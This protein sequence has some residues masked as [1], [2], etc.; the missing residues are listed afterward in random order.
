M[1]INKIK[2]MG[3]YRQQTEGTPY[4]IYQACLGCVANFKNTDS[5][6]WMSLPDEARAYLDKELLRRLAEEYLEKERAMP[7]NGQKLFAH[8]IA[9]IREVDEKIFQTI[10]KQGVHTMSDRELLEINQKLGSQTYKMWLEFFM[11]IFDVDAEG[12]IEHELVNEKI[13]LLPEEKNIMMLQNELLV[14]QREEKNL[15]QIAVQIKNNPGALNTFLYLSAPGNLHRLKL[16]PEIEKALEQHQKNFFWTKNSWAHTGTVPIFDYVEI[17]KQMLFSS[18]DT[19]EE[20]KRLESFEKD[21]L[22]KK[23]M[24]IKKYNL[25]PWL[26]KMFEFF[27]L[28]SYWRDE[29]KVEMQKMNHYLELLGREIGRRSGFDWHEIKF[30]NPCA[31]KGIPVGKQVVEDFKKFISEQYVIVWDG[32]KP[33]HLSPQECA[34]ADAAVEASIQAEMTEIRGMIACPGK[35]RG[36]VVV[37]N[38]KEEF[39]KMK[40]GMILVANMTRPEFVPLMKKAAAIVTDEGGI[41]SHAAV[42]SRELK[43]PCIIGTLVATKN[44]KDGDKVFVNADHGVVVVLE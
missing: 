6:M 44:L 24:I 35:V 32:H 7:G 17:I 43:V 14:L 31:I 36:E 33:V 1:D 21:L 2:Q 38:K 10:D 20:L 13:N 23:K 3:W 40:E 4:F 34:E 26:V 28:L 5:I 29:R 30:M 11:D 8:W 41:T 27:N 25:S 22:A 9:N 18:R 37:I 39:G 12:L 16:Y 19:G 15:L 42:V